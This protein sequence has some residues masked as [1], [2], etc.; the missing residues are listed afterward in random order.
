[1]S[2]P[3]KRIGL[4][5]GGRSAEHEVSKLSAANVL[6]A[7]DPDRYDIVPIGIGRD[8]RWVLC[9]SGNGARARRQVPGDS[10]RS[11]AGRPASR[12]RR[13]DDRSGWQ[14]GR[15][16]ASSR[17]DRARPPRAERRGRHGPGLSRTRERSLCRLG[18]DGL[19]C[20]HGQGHRQTPPARQRPAGRSLPHAD[21]PQ[22]Y[23]LPGGGR[24]PRH[25]GSV[26]QAGQYGLVRRRVPR[27]FA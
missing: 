20:R 23:R 18:R 12:R 9:D 11:A 3:R 22:P 2:Q 19:R 24:R 4:L 1:M 14:R 13:R 21:A 8:G 26:R 15:K 5:F 10:A 16:D 25:A 17:R 7:L 27:L 6:R